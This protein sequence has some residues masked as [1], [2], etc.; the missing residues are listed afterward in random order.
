MSMREKIIVLLAVLAVGYGVYVLFF[1]GSGG[2]GQGTAPQATGSQTEAT[3]VASQV[4]STI[5]SGRLNE[6]EFAILA[7][8][9]EPWDRDPF[10]TRTST[11]PQGTAD[12]EQPGEEVSFVYSGYVEIGN[13]RYAVI[14]GEEY[15]TGEEL[16]PAGYFVRD[17]LPDQVVIQGRQREI[18]T[19]L[20]EETY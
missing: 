18:T 5:A 13:R 10:H 2:Q 15:T 3:T 4:Q 20:I 17:I 1:E 6:S 16:Q 19:P 7:K 14:N 12:Q 8:A 9:R 11:R